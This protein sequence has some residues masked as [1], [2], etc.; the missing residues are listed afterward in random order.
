L[1]RYN[2]D[3]SLDATFGSGGRVITDFF[4]GD[5]A[6]RALALQSDGKIVVLGGWSP[7]P[8]PGCCPL[9]PTSIALARYNPD[10]T[11][12]AT[13]GSGGKVTTGL[14]YFAITGFPFPLGMALQPDGKIVI[15]TSSTLTR[16][17]PDGTLDASFVIESAGLAL[18]LQPDGK[19]VLARGGKLLSFPCILAFCP[20]DF[21]LTRYNP[22]GTPD[23]TFGNKGTA[24][25]DFPGSM[26]WPS[27]L[28]L[29]PDGKIVVAGTSTPFG[30]SPNFALARFEGGPF[31]NAPILGLHLN[32]RTFAPSDTLRM[33][34]TAT[35]LGP[36]FNADVYFGALFPD[37]TTLV[38]V[39]KLAPP[40]FV[41]ADLAGDARSFRPLLTN[42]H[43]PEGFTDEFVSDFQYT[44]SG[45]EPSGE[46][47]AFVALVKPGAF[48][49][50]RLDPGDILVLALKTFTFSGLMTV[51]TPITPIHD[52]AFES[53][54]TSHGVCY[55]LF[56]DWTDSQSFF[57]IFGYFIAVERQGAPANSGAF[58]FAIVSA[59][60]LTATRCLPFDHPVD[61]WEW[62]VQ[63]ID[64][65]GN[66]SPWSE[67]GT[68]RL[69]R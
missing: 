44:F 64:N 4:G 27:A 67:P 28:A 48:R 22:N 36:A 59:S 13:F 56:F 30:G 14:S 25:T 20:T 17:N 2:P 1:A 8:L 11:L 43:M 41:V 19:I 40:A 51:P 68:F 58:L 18:G 54:H 57:G 23:L 60:E 33:D 37:G 24:T 50:G 31:D 47:Q 32:R 62:R 61:G 66:V 5:D 42:V 45:G 49:D 52:A 3:G 7:P 10:G 9:G 63:A 69:E 26:F 39:T 16:F 53:I 29:Q 65:L 35:N 6:A 21:N 38:F 55:D 12:D 46:Y 15:V 34:V